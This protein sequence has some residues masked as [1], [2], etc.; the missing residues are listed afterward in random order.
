MAAFTVDFLVCWLLALSDSVFLA[1]PVDTARTS[2][3]ARNRAGKRMDL[4]FTGIPSSLRA[5][6]RPSYCPDLPRRV[7]A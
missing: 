3:T 7:H 5:E 2:A 6:R 4:S 1:H